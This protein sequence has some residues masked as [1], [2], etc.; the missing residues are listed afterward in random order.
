[1]NQESEWKTCQRENRAW[2]Q[3]LR[4]R[5]QAN[6]MQKVDAALREARVEDI[7]RVSTQLGFEKMWFDS[8]YLLFRTESG[9]SI[10]L[11]E[12]HSR[13]QSGRPWQ[14]VL[15]NWIKGEF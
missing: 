3:V 7:S 2:E 12:V 5:E 4:G 1:M 11:V 13:A 10:S 9:R 6:Q 15:I 8:H 14:Q